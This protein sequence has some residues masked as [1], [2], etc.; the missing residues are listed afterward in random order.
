MFVQ[1]TVMPVD[2]V[3]AARDALGGEGMAR[4]TLIV[5]PLVAVDAALPPPEQAVATS[6]RHD[7]RDTPT[8]PLTP[9]RSESMGD[10]SHSED[11][12]PRGHT[13]G[14]LGPPTAAVRC[15]TADAR[16]TADA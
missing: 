10:T 15:G 2:L 6:A 1:C 3:N 11:V 12:P 14:V 4:A 8:T 5:T 7:R 9:R 16:V 13:P